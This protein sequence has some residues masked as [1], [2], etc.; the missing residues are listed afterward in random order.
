MGIEVTRRLRKRFPDDSTPIIACTTSSVDVKPKCLAAGMNGFI[1][2][3]FSIDQLGLYLR[4]FL[5]TRS[6]WNSYYRGI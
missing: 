3:P 5:P 4:K 6:Q 1:E 2:K